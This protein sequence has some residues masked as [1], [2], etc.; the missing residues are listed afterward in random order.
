M[1]SSGLPGREIPP[2]SQSLV[3]LPA[4]V[5]LQRLPSPGLPGGFVHFWRWLDSWRCRP[6]VILSSCQSG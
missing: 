4:G 1:Q 6:G 5:L 2:L 3:V